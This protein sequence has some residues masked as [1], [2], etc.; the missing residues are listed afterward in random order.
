MRLKRHLRDYQLRKGSTG[1]LLDLG[2]EGKEKDQRMWLIYELY[3]R[4]ERAVIKERSMRFNV[5]SKRE[6][7]VSV[8]AR[9]G[10]GLG[11]NQHRVQE[12]IVG[13]NQLPKVT[14]LMVR[15]VVSRIPVAVAMAVSKDHPH[16][17]V[18]YLPLPLQH[19]HLTI[20]QNPRAR[21]HVR[22]NRQMELVNQTFHQ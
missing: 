21:N 6:R 10:L 22:S 16:V 14:A 7:M 17:V 18:P 13:R 5:I 15:A 2:L 4:I 1:Q 9:L 20:R 12:M 8:P 3:V 19:H 11:L